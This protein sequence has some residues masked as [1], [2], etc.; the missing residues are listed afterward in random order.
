MKFDYSNITNADFSD[1]DITNSSVASTAI[2]GNPSGGSTAYFFNV[3]CPD[4]TVANYPDTCV[5]HGF[6]P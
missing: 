1:A 2:T 3:T 5:G 6:A 4:L